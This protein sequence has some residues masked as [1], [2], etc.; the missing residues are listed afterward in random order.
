MVSPSLDVGGAAVGAVNTFR[1][2]GLN[3]P[4]L[5]RCI[6][7]EDFSSS[8]KVMPLCCALPGDMV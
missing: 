7:R 2:M 5:S 6:V 1:P 3:E 4:R 8:M